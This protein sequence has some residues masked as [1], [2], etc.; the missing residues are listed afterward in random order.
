V[1]NS[2][3]LFVALY[4]G[5]GQLINGSMPVDQFVEALNTMLAEATAGQ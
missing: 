3:P 5:Q 1:S 2:T 4:G